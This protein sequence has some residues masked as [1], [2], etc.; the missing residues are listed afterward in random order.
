MEILKRIG[1][2]MAI[3]AG[4]AACFYGLVLWFE[5][6]ERYSFWV[7]FAPLILAELVVLYMAV[8]GVRG[9]GSRR[10]AGK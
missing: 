2:T 4:I 6:A 7:V 3:A 5:W 1:I 8:G 10:K 9:T